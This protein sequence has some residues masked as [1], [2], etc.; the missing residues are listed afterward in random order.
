MLKDFEQYLNN[1]NY[2]FDGNVKDAVI[3]S[4]VDGGKR[5][6][7]HLLLALLKD[8]GI[9]VERGY[10]SALAIDMIHSYSVVLCDK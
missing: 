3:Y 10:S 1:Y 6:R 2:G 8:Y 4:I 7:P 9:S 5:I